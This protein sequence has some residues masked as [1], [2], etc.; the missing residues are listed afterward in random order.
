MAATGDER[1]LVCT[2][3]TAAV[4]SYELVPPLCSGT[5]YYSCVRSSIYVFLESLLADRIRMPA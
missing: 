2:T 3:G 1:Y 4:V 5:S